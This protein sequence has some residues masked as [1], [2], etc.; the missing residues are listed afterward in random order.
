MPHFGFWHHHKEPTMP[1]DA[2]VTLSDTLAALAAGSAQTNA[3][4]DALITALTAQAAR[5]NDPAPVAPSQ[6][7]AETEPAA[8]A[9]P[10]APEGSSL[11]DRLAAIEAFI[12]K[13]APVVEELFTAAASITGGSIGSVLAAA[14]KALGHV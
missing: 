9:S 8:P 14:A 10:I 6:V 4:L 3:K 2:P 1:D 7:L 13:H 11:D 5:S 12:V